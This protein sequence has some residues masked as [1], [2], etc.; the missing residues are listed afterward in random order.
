MLASELGV[1]KEKIVVVPNGVDTN[2]FYADSGR[3]DQMRDSLGVSAGTPLIL[4]FGKLD[5]KPNSQALDIILNRVLPEVLNEVPD[6]RFLVAGSNPPSDLSHDNLV[7]VGVVDLI[8]DYINA[9]DV[10]ICPL[11]SGGG[12]RFKILEAI[13]CGKRV[14]STTIGAEGLEG[15]ET[16]HCLTCVDD[17]SHFAQEVV[18]AIRNGASLESGEAFT[19]KYDWRHVTEPLRS[20]IIRRS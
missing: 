18:R 4:F 17:W 7:F 11:T 10:V 9:S 20:Q 1:A 2:K 16:E 15:R 3:R 13:A 6:A 19:Q 5:Y 14:I 12:T 8:E